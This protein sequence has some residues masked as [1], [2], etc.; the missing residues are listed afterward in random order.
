[1]IPG[2]RRKPA[3][4]YCGGR[5][6]Q[7]FDLDRVMRLV[8]C[9]GRTQ[10]QTAKINSSSS[11]RP[12]PA[13]IWLDK[14]AVSGVKSIRQSVAGAA[15]IGQPVGAEG[16]SAFE[17]LK[18]HTIDIRQQKYLPSANLR[19]LFRQKSR[20]VQRCREYAH[21]AQYPSKGGARRPMAFSMLPGSNGVHSPER[22]PRG[23]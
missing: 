23:Q 17:A 15:L 2:V 8:V 13:T 7:P 5:T 16:G 4:L 14:W 18:S 22:A 12:V 1:M 10:L 21:D 9:R 19:W 3:R 6:L 11:W 20:R